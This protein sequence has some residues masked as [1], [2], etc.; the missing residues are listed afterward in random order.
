M[1]PV[2]DTVDGRRRRLIAVG[3][4]AVVSLAA[5]TSGSGGGGAGADGS[6]TPG[7]S[8]P[9]TSTAPARPT[10]PGA[11]STSRT[12]GAP[13]SGTP[14]SF[15]PPV[16]RGSD[17]LALGDSVSFGYRET[18]TRPAPDYSDASD[19]T[20]FPE[21]VGDAL[22]LHVANASCP[23]ETSASLIDTSA[24]TFGCERSAT[25]G[26]G[27]RTNSPLHVDYQGAQL[28]YGVRYLRT[29]RDTRLVT[30]MVGA[31]DAFRCVAKTSDHCISEFGATLMT[32]R[33]NVA[34]ILKS[35]RSKAHY[36]GRIVVVTY[37]AED[38]HGI[39][40]AEST[41]LNAA[42]TQGARGYRVLVADGYAAF[43]RAARA[44]NGDSCR[45]GLLTKLTSGG[46]GVH[47]S[48]KG[49]RLLATAVENA[50]QAT[51]S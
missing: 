3:L 9:D 17:Y 36:A 14:T 28:A 10:S 8:R 23:G 6:T 25:G 41:S 39:A 45:A 33:K 15:G 1:D 47:P 7:T 35:V 22:H 42:V 4:A 5:C 49:Q 40:A 16:T 31:N 11:A 12:P 44:D 2:T 51:G 34:T 26:D 37:Y 38:Y 30:L 20:G 21:L 46:C 24:A 19:F 13:T 50:A 29:H 43:Q 18:D 32:V 27:Y 48:E